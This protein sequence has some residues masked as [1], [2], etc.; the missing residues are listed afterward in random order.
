MS[1]TAIVLANGYFDDL[2]AKTAHGLVRGP[3]RYPLAAVVDPEA[4]ESDAGEALDGRH[5]GI[6]IFDS[7]ESVLAALD[8]RPDYCVVG[9]ATSGGHLPDDVRR[10]LMTAA[11]AGLTLVNGL[12][13]LLT[14]DAEIARAT[15]ESGGAIIDLR[16][17]KPI[18]EL[19]FWTGEVLDVAAPC[20]PILGTD[21]AIGKR[22]TCNWLRDGLRER[23]VRAEMIYTGQTGWLQGIPHGFILDSTVNDFVSGELEGA[24]LDCARE[25]DPEVI[26]I[27]GQAA[28]R[29]PSGPCGSEL[30]IS[31]AAAGVILQHA[32]REHYID[33]VDID[34]R[35]PSLE[36]EIQLV[37]M[38]GSEVWALSLFPEGLD[39]EQAEAE[40]SRLAD[41]LGIPV[42][43]PSADG[44]LVDVVLR[45][46]TQRTQT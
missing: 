21:C 43:L 45:R 10:D 4:A 41:R 2:H 14:D 36:S 42:C 24:I 34:Y 32:P 5:R 40:R 17:P 23:G 7:V 19:R 9:V 38:L 29:N 31:T 39:G 12:H 26:L 25:T 15:A 3:S 37:E 28:L 33:W 18:S 11:R 16:R 22:T 44:E 1:G 20:I 27:E 46:V 6:P 30:I 13:Q 35:I 8:S